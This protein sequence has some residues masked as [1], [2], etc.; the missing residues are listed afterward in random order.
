MFHDKHAAAAVAADKDASLRSTFVRAHVPH[1]VH[2]SSSSSRTT[3]HMLLGTRSI[4]RWA[5]A[6]RARKARRR[7]LKWN[8]VSTIQFVSETNTTAEYQVSTRARELTLPKIPTFS[9]WFALH[10]AAAV[11]AAGRTRS[12]HSHSNECTNRTTT[13]FLWQNI[14]TQIV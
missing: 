2:G 6:R 14:Y 9:D 7:K 12:H 8:Y 10:D 4:R 1:H 5:S 13:Y 11:A 3:T